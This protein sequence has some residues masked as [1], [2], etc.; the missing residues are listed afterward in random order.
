M[1]KRTETPKQ[2]YY[3]FTSSLCIFSAL[4]LRLL[5]LLLLLL[6]ICSFVKYS[7]TYFLS[8]FQ[9]SSSFSHYCWTRCRS[10]FFYVLVSYEQKWNITFNHRCFGFSSHVIR[11][12]SAVWIIMIYI[13]SR[14]VIME[15][16]SSN[17]LLKRWIMT[18]YNFDFQIRKCNKQ[19]TQ[20]I[21]SNKRFNDWFFATWRFFVE[22]VSDWIKR[23]RA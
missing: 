23:H 19:A 22:T 13:V 21:L 9:T 14:S 10:V 11:I 8:H 6:L 5:L 3:C 17:N 4:F 2:N 20:I 16:V 18:W 15:K 7:A 12:A 1:T